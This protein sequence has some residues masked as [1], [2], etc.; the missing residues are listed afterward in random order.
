MKASQS[1]NDLISTATSLFIIFSKI[2]R[3]AYE[4]EHILIACER[5]KFESFFTKEQG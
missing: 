3:F 2:P 1:K 4:S 5:I